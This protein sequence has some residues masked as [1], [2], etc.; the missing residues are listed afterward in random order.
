VAGFDSTPDSLFNNVFNGSSDLFNKLELA[1]S[2][3]AV[4]LARQNVQY[5]TNNDLDN[6]I[7]A[8]MTLEISALPVAGQIQSQS[9][10]FTA[11]GTGFDN[12]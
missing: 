10:T 3:D 1:K 12:V 4:L 2:L 6:V 7:T 9:W 11:N 5:E 8:N